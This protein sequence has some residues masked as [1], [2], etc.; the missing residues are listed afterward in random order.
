MRASAGVGAGGR[1]V[2]SPR[3]EGTATHAEALWRRAPLL[4]LLLAVAVAIVFLGLMLSATDGHFVPQVVDSYLVFQYARAMAEG[5]PFQYVAGEP[6]STGATSLLHTAVLAL[7][8]AVGFRGEGL[9]AFAILTGAGLLCVSVV[10]AF[11]LGLR[12]GGRRV[13][14]LAGALVALGGPVSWGFLY[15]ADIALFMALALWL[16]GAIDD[17]WSAGRVGGLAACGVVL[18]LS[19]PE[20]LVIALVV[21][22]CWTLGPGRGR[23]RKDLLAV[24]SPVAA[25]LAVLALY[26]VVTGAW[27]GTSVADK[28]LFATYGLADGLALAAEY[29]VDVVRGLLLGFFPS[30]APIGFGR[31]WASLAFPPLGL[32]LVLTTLATAPDRRPLR[33]WAGAAA[34]VFVLVGPNMFQGTHFNRYLLW[35]FPGLLVLAAAGLH[36]LCALLT[37]GD[38]RL[39]RDLF[40]FGA[41]LLVLLGA[42]STLRFAVMYGDMAGL[43]Y[44]RDLAAADWIRKNLPPG[45]AI[46]NQ[47]TSVEYLTGHRSVNLHGVTTPAFFGNRAGER[48]AGSVEV[49]ARLPAAER[50]PYLM[51]TAA[52]LEASPA[53]REMASAEPVFRTASLS[54]EIAIH[55]MTYALVDGGRTPGSASALAAVAGLTEVDRLNVCDARDERAHGYRFRS[56]V[57]TAPLY[58][59]TRVDAY[60][61]AAGARFADGGRAILGSESFRV[62]TRPGRDLT[63]V[64]RTAPALNVNLYRAAGPVS[65]AIEMPEEALSV[66]IDGRLL[67]RQ[68][69]HPPQG[70]SDIVLR[71]PADRIAGDAT[72]VELSGRY[73]AFR[74]WFYQ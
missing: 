63:I 2:T 65:Y 35:A 58:G 13:G 40:A 20:G 42:L 6:A 68:S 69:F 23:T 14:A 24:W 8:H 37:L 74:Y 49:L 29:G 16:L 73:A 50:P 27:T 9:A 41:A 43:V 4:L 32:L 31:G 51:T 17:A 28:S 15:G 25:G 44:R 21:A 54:D 47:A 48:D 70:W 7:A 55:A 18:S 22:V 46:A 38:R 1:V 64:M 72:D 67:G 62:R 11:R 52:A 26:R 3:M 10:L 59:S 39:D 66:R 33:V 36:H 12:L 34:L 5:H 71:V 19:R 61:D 30:Q 45:V 56:R 60:A 53:L 57:G